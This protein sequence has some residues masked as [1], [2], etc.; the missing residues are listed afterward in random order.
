MGAAAMTSSPIIAQQDLG[1]E[2]LLDRLRR[3]DTSAVDSCK[4]LVQRF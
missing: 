1:P 4:D 2:E 3:R